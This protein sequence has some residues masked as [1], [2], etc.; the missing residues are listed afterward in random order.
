LAGN[1]GVAVG[2]AAAAESNDNNDLI[3]SSCDPSFMICARESDLSLALTDVIGSTVIGAVVGALVGREQWDRANV[4]TPSHRSA[5][6]LLT[7]GRDR[8]RVGVHA[9][10]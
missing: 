6:L 7:P 5:R 3:D 2:A 10:F 8:V 9:T 1:V 4:P